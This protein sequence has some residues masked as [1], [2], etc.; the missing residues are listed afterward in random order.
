MKDPDY[1][2]T[3]KRTGWNKLQQK[4]EFCRPAKILSKGW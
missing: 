4:R 1:Y 3:L 2:E